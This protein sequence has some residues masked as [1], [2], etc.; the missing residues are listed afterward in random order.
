MLKR[1]LLFLSLCLLTI[2]TAAGQNI[3]VKGTVLDENSEPIIGA[4]VRLKDDA[5]KGALTDIDGR[6]TLQVR[7]GQILLVTFVGYK[8]L[9]VAA[10]PNLTIRLEPENQLLEEVMVVAFGTAK[11][12]AFTGSAVEVDNKELEKRQVSNVTAALTGKVPGITVTNGN[13]QPGTTSSITIRGIG[14]FSAGTGPLYVVDG[15][16]FDGDI[17]TINPQ[18]IQSTTVLKDAASA[19]LYGARGANGVIIITTKNGARSGGKMNITFD[20]RYGTNAREIGD[21]DVMKD[22]KIYAA[23]YFE[24]IYNYWRDLTGEDGSK[25]FTNADDVYKAAVGTYFGVPDDSGKAQASL[26]YHPFTYA[27]KA[28]PF[29]RQADGSFVMDPK[30]TVGGLY[31]DPQG[32]DYWLQPDDWSEYIFSTNPRQEYNLSISGANEKANYYMSAGFLDDK[33]YTVGSGFQRFT[34]RLR[35]DFTPYKWIKMGGNLGYTY[36]NYNQISNTTEGGNSGNIFAMTNFMAPLFPMYVRDGDGNIM[37]DKWGNEI[38]DYGNQTYPGLQRPYLAI[39]N[40]LANNILD[41]HDAKADVLSG[42][43]YM[44]FTF[45]EGL[46]LTLNVGYDSDNTYGTDVNNPYYGQFAGQGGIITKWY[47]RTH[48]FNTQQLLTYT[49]SFGKNNF[50]IL[51]GHEFYRYK[52]EYFYGW[53]NGIYNPENTEL[54]GALFEP[55]T[56]STHSEYSTEGYLG[57]FQYDY[58]NTYFLSASYR[59]DA[60]SRFAPDHRWGNFWSVG[61]SWLISSEDFMAGAKNWLDLLKVKVSYGMQGNDA[62]GS[63]R[64]M[65]LYTLAK[66]GETGYA[67]NF[68][69]KGNEN[70]TWETSG[71]FNAG[72]EFSLFKERLSGGV[73]FYIREVSDMLFWQ[74]APRSAGYSGY[75]ANIG[76]MKNTGVDFNLKAVFLKTKNFY[77]DIYV[78]GGYFKNTLTKL[79][80]EWEADELGYRSGNSVYKV[81]GSIYDIALAHYLGV[82]EKG[83][84]TWEFSDPE[85]GEKSVTTKPSEGQQKQS[86]WIFTDVAPKINGGFGTN[87]EF[88][89]IDLSAS[90]TYALGGRRI[91]STYQ[92]LMH[93]GA[94]GEAGSNWHMDILNSWTPENTN[95]DIPQISWGG[96]GYANATSDRFLISRDYLSIDNVTVGYTIPKQWL[97]KAGISSLRIYFAGDNLYVFS[98]R[99]GYDPRFGGGVGYKAIRSLSGGLKLTF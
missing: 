58:D 43:G 34:A 62:V 60:S 56:G 87:I 30:T 40:P 74:P 90:L 94:S 32:K 84:P 78:N 57:R 63:F 75:Y 99:K 18:D 49:K 71:N 27:D 86:R 95:T 64:Y 79:P 61:A 12:A 13:N 52:Y 10:A 82:N 51:A 26:V 25:V 17:S 24:G 39:A 93:D 68:S 89:G 37:I 3:T 1:L 55:M 35:S 33:G 73:D 47:S 4:T 46:K 36:T 2:G 48:S 15:V 81:G 85:T 44:D 20:A 14:S 83:E 77:W 54:E 76:S 59:R 70:L 97:S 19:A 31:T 5:T 67:V 41:Y 88:F 9:E 72:I 80:A 50:D 11:K 21:Y 23:K 6:F 42:R 92:S 96:K 22:P 7:Q 38:Y 65:D 53:K 29:I 66:S 69:D 28:N 98:A 16:P 8:N 45:V 91:D